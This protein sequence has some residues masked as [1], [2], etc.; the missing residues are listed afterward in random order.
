MSESGVRTSRFSDVEELAASLPDSSLIA[1][2]L[3]AGGFHA[4]IT[5][6]DL[7][8]IAL[9]IGRTTPLL[10]LAS[11]RRD[12]A[13]VL[14]PLTGQ[15]AMILNGRAIGA[16]DIAVYSPGAEH[17]GAIRSEATFTA[18]TLPVETA[19]RVFLSPRRPALLRDGTHAMLRTDPAAWA[20]AASLARS[21]AQ[22]V[23]SDPAIFEIDETRRALRDTV[24]D[25]MRELLT[26]PV[27]GAPARA[28]RICAARSRLI[29][30]AKDYIVANPQRAPSVAGLSYALGVSASRLR[31]AFAASFA[32]GPRAS[33]KLQRLAMARSALR[34]SDPGTSSIKS[35]ASEYGFW[36]LDGFV[37]DYRAMFA[38]DPL[39]AFGR[40]PAG[41]PG[42]PL[43]RSVSRS[44]I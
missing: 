24:L 26:G 21:V 42:A 20:R 23:A 18:L 39:A 14:L 36:H 25:V 40:S 33:L 32:I 8:D 1:L 44:A 37:R 3:R 29:R 27:D 2:P 4:E 41:G 43:R 35:I 10:A 16:H 12:R 30:R 38:E 17:N 13:H 22:V 19:R 7:G 6:I 31:S 5:Q 9:R 15:D 34:A 11:V 28:L